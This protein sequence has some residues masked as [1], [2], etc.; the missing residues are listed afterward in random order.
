MSR[1]P[2]PKGSLIWGSL[3]DFK[4]DTLGFLAGAVR[5]HGD[6]VRLRFGPVTA[7]LLNRPEY[8]EHVLSRHGANYDKATRSAGRIKATTGNS[9]LSADH[10]TWQR[11]RGLIQPAFQPRSFDAIEPVLDA[12][13]SPMLARWQRAGGVDI[14]DEMMGLVIAAAIKI[15]FS[16]DIDPA[17]ISIPLETLLQDT[18]RRIEAPLDASIL[19]KHLHRPAFKSA[20]AQI[21]AIVLDLIQTRRRSGARPDDVLSRLIA[22]HEDEHGAQLSDLELRDAAVTLLLAGHE[23]TANALSWAF[24][25][26]GGQAGIRAGNAAQADPAHIFAEAI[27]LHPS[28]WVI[29]RRAVEDDVIGGFEIPRGS[30]VL[31]S[32]YLLHRHPE[33]WPDPEVFD[34]NRFTAGVPRPRDA[35]LPYGLGAHRCV[36]LHLANKMA[37]HILMRVRARVSLRLRSDQILGEVA[38]I[39]LRHAAPVFM[40]VEAATSGRAPS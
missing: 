11:H 33:F 15:L 36:G 32:P 39:T 29:E 5:D 2:G 25:H 7:H 31:I 8:V 17:T 22:A 18:W 1:A 6:I 34:P 20:L 4:T 26:A 3:Q 14:V 12:L 16:A 19:S 13:I 9:L 24:I 37:A 23:T 21:D 35:Y 27:R 10:P 40:E 28:I 30:S 38:Q